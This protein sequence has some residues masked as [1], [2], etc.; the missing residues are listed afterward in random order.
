MQ[1]MDGISNYKS[2][3]HDTTKFQFSLLVWSNFS[4]NEEI[5]RRHGLKQG[6]YLTIPFNRSQFFRGHNASFPNFR[7]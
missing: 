1:G 3:M 7:I 6:N 4:R 5:M 2:E